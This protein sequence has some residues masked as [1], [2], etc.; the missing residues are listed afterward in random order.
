MFGPKEVW[1][2]IDRLIP[3]KIPDT[4]RDSEHRRGWKTVRVFVSSTFKD[5]HYEREVLVKQVSQLSITH[6]LLHMLNYTIFIS[7]YM[8]H[9]TCHRNNY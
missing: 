2:E 1:E 4:E 3:D 5:F 7:S 9:F 8:L 6:G